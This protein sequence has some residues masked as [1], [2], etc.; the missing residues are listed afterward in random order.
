MKWSIHR[1][2]LVVIWI[3]TITHSHHIEF[4]FTVTVIIFSYIRVYY[5]VLNRDTIYLSSILLNK[6]NHHLASPEYLQN[7][8]RGLQE[9]INVCVHQ[10]FSFIACLSLSRVHMNQHPQMKYLT[11][12]QTVVIYVTVP[13]QITNEIKAYHASIQ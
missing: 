3:N 7:N 11:V 9:I 5:S 4:L 10:C 12:L 6:T 2:E 8:W 1:V 13:T